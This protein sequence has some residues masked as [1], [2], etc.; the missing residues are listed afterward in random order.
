MSSY[1]F[2][3]TLI[4]FIQDCQAEITVI[5]TPSVKPV[6]VGETVTLKCKTSRDVPCCY[7]RTSS[8]RSGSAH[9]WYHQKPGEAPKLLIYYTYNLQSGTP[10]RF[11]GS[12]SNTDFTLSISGVKSEDAG[13]YYCQSVH[14]INSRDV[15]TQ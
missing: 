9:S 11:S 10:S 6:T 12:G 4:I 1:I 15:L 7:T 14:Y 3:W 13:H 2:I 8:D 5:Q